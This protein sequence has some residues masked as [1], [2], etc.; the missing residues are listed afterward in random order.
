MYKGH[1]NKYP[2]RFTTYNPVSTVPRLKPDAILKVG[3]FKGKTVEWII[4]YHPDYIDWA[5][6]NKV[7][8]VSADDLNEIRGKR[9]T[10]AELKNLEVLYDMTDDREEKANLAK[11]Y[12]ELKEKMSAKNRAPVGLK[13]ILKQKELEG[14]VY[15]IADNNG[16]IKIGKAIDPHV[17]MRDLQIGN[18][19]KLTLLFYVNGGYRLENRVHALLYDFRIQGEWFEDCKQLREVMK[20]LGYDKSI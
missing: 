1:V 8:Y 2:G 20:S 6:R 18:P 13:D 14:Y 10:K 15:F 17:R 7:F 19:D 9:G 12:K 16:R 4:K 3:K 5:R 11:Q